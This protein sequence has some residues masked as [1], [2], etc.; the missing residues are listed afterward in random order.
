MAHHQITDSIYVERAKFLLNIFE[1]SGEIENVKTLFSEC[2]ISFMTEKCFVGCPSVKE[3]HRCLACQET[4]IFQ[5]SLI[6]FK[7]FGR[8]IIIKD[9]INQLQIAVNNYILEDKRM[10]HKCNK[11][12]KQIEKQ[13]QVALRIETDWLT[14]N[15]KLSEIPHELQ[16][17]TKK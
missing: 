11:K 3:I 14:N 13:C 16:I 2:N 10:C 15:C 4:K 5:N 8:E 6:V 9:G 12:E 7:T 1:K 17:D